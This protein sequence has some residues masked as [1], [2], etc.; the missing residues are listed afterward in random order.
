MNSLFSNR[1]TYKNISPIDHRYATASPEL[2][3]SL[4]EVL[5]EEA[6]ISFEV[7]VEKVVAQQFVRLFFRNSHSQ[8]QIEDFVHSIEKAASKVKPNDI[9]QEEAETK[10]HIRAVVRIFAKQLPSKLARLVHVGLTSADVIDTAYSLRLK[11]YVQKL[12]VPHLSAVCKKLVSLARQECK[13]M[14]IGRTHGQFAVPITTGYFFSSYASRLSTAIEEIIARTKTLK[15]KLS[16]AVGAFHALGLVI[17]DPIAFER[18]TLQLLGLQ[19]CEISTQIVQPEY[20]IRLRSEIQLALGIIADLA[21]DLR[22][23]SRSEIGE[24]SETFSEDQVGSSTMPHKRNPWNCEHVKS[25]WKVATPQLL[26]A[27]F[28]QLSEHQR[29]LTNSASTRFSIEWYAIVIQAIHRMEYILNGLYVHRNRMQENLEQAHDS[30]LAEPL[31][32]LLSCSGVL[33]A[34]EHV[35][36]LIKES[37]KS[38]T[39]LREVLGGHTDLYEHCTQ[40]LNEIGFKT[41]DDFFVNPS[42]YHGKCI[43]MTLQTCK[44]IEKRLTASENFLQEANLH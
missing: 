24:F 42:S 13:T 37:K 32:I 33:N 35:R 30:V 1:G 28:D 20:A 12:L 23:L 22:H 11:E 7:L 38:G 18:E 6:S 39:S 9:Y 15:G 31:Y 44:S 43:E 5:S 2:F 36:E 19:A 27:F 17:Q 29:D 14:Q 10:H 40:Y 41:V 16:G 34:Y 21:D 4:S 3:A 26:T 8:K 25:L